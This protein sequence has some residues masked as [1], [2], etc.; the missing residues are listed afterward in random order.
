MSTSTATSN[1]AIPSLQTNLQL[2][3]FRIEAL[4]SI[5]DRNEY[6]VWAKEA[7]KEQIL[8]RQVRSM[9]TDSRPTASTSS[10]DPTSFG[11]TD[12]LSSSAR[13]STSVTPSPQWTANAMSE[14]QADI[15]KLSTRV[16]ALD[17]DIDLD[18]QQFSVRRWLI[19]QLK[20]L[21][22]RLR[23]INP[24][25]S[26]PPIPAYHH[27]SH[28]A[29]QTAGTLEMSAPATRSFS[30]QTN[31]MIACNAYVQTD[32]MISENTYIQTDGTTQNVL[33]QTETI[34]LDHANIETD[35]TISRNP[36]VHA[37]TQTAAPSSTLP[38][39][40]NAKTQTDPHHTDPETQYEIAN[41]YLEGCRKN[42][43]KGM[44]HLKMAANRGHI[45][46]MYKLGTM[47][48]S[49]W[50]E[51][52]GNPKDN[53][54]AMRCNRK[55]AELGCNQSQFGVGVLYDEGL[56]VD[57]DHQ[58]ALGWFLKSAM[59]GS[60]AA[61]S[62]LGR[63]HHLGLGVDVDYVKAAE[64]YEKAAAQG[65]I[66]AQCALG[67]LYE[68]GLGVDQDYLKAAEW[69]HDAAAQGAG[70]ALKTLGGT[71]DLGLGVERDFVK[72][73]VM[74]RRAADKRKMSGRC[75][76]GKLLEGGRGIGR[77]EG[78]AFDWY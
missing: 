58:E 73:S 37:T 22:E 76:L 69:Y 62:R 74:Y 65:D 51:N 41:M 7:A 9:A 19:R 59:Q 44:K 70:Y 52:T 30:V 2:L 53:R 24:S 48:C 17:N 25:R 57:V 66:F 31:A 15:Q 34:D 77:N 60:S 23:E 20:S 63:L 49:D 71:Y 14:L 43:Q 8:L 50:P 38:M 55:G 61:Q 42:T 18:F 54:E 12:T 16:T 68:E 72:A 40:R 35:T 10:K 5:V 29:T 26:S 39:T 45:T 21:S 4:E 64:W 47:Y 33:V 11:L 56:G 28:L 36:P 78:K 32:A 67:G 46:A 13:S 27:L 1:D 6:N 3:V 75:C